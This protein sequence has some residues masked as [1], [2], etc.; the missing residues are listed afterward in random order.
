MILESEFALIQVYGSLTLFL[1]GDIN[2]TVTKA[3]C[4]DAIEF[5]IIQDRRENRVLNTQLDI[6]FK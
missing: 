5:K 3:L 2:E 6:F 4:S 1:I